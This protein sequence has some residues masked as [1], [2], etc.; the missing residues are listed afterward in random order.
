MFFDETSNNE[1]TGSCMSRPIRSDYKHYSTGLIRSS[2]T[3]VRTV[4]RRN[5]EQRSDRKWR[6]V[7]RVRISCWSDSI[8]QKNRPVARFWKCSVSK[9]GTRRLPE[10]G[11]LFTKTFAFQ[12]AVI[13]PTDNCN[14][15]TTYTTDNPRTAAMS[16]D[17]LNDE[18]HNC[19]C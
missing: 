2:S 10:S 14:C 15:T 19:L 18:Y 1:T 6:V 9:L 3:R 4:L 17:F 8:V 11:V 12:T 5:R 16:G 13:Q 7:S